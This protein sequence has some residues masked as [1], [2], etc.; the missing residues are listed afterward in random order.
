M[1]VEEYALEKISEDFSR[2]ARLSKKRRRI[3]E[4]DSYR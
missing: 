1:C 4:S 3:V 2:D